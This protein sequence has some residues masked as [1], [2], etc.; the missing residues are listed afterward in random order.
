MIHKLL[1][2]KFVI[3]IAVFFTSLSSLFFIASG[4]VRSVEG[5][6]G[7][8]QTAFNVHNEVKPGLSLL[9]GL[10]SFIVALVFLIFSMGMAKLFLFDHIKND[11]LP[12]WLH[13]DDLKELKI[14]LWETILVALVVIFITHTIKA[15]PQAWEALIFPIII[16]ILSASLYLVK[17]KG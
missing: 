16:L 9:E 11:D 8:F 13:V 15:E 5:Y 7:Y 4:V 2:I 17:K 1:R 3:S 12:K 10:D 6:L 14:L